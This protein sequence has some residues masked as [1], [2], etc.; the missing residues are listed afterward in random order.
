MGL[1]DV[2]L[3]QTTSWKALSVALLAA[4][5][6]VIVSTVSTFFGRIALGIIMGV[7]CAVLGVFAGLR[8]QR[9]E[10]IKSMKASGFGKGSATAAVVI[11]QKAVGTGYGSARATVVPHS[12]ECAEFEKHSQTVGKTHYQV[13]IQL[14]EQ[15]ACA[16]HKR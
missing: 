10:L 8:M 9:T 7:L 1:S 16:C 15:C 14:G 12:P 4:I 6:G 11:S 2:E 3:K 5:V 13:P